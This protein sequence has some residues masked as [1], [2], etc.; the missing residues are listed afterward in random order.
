M[1][2]SRDTSIG[3]W[4]F[5]LFAWDGLLPPTIWLVPM[6][7]RNLMPKNDVAFAFVIVLLPIA[8][9]FVRYYAGMKY[10]RENNCGRIMRWFQIRV[11]WVAILIMVLIDVISIT[12]QDIV[13]FEEQIVFA[14]LAYAFYLPLMAFALYPG[15]GNRSE[16][17]SEYG[18]R[19]T[20]RLNV[21]GGEEYV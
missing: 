18:L 14:L 16:A 19:Q 20:T 12:M 15:F 6:L 10:I 8:A 2:D 5:R 17:G 1:H 3:Q 9:L 4:L 7:L 11:L 13:P 21:F